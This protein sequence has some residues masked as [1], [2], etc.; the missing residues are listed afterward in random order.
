MDEETKKKF[1][2]DLEERVIKTDKIVRDELEKLDLSYEEF[3]KL[4]S[5]KLN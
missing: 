2:A 1:I 3:L 4:Q 5:F